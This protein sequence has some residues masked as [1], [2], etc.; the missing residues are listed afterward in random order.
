MEKSDRALV[1]QTP[2]GQNPPNLWAVD[3]LSAAQAGTATTEAEARVRD[4]DLTFS[5]GRAA[6]PSQKDQLRIDFAGYK[7]EVYGIAA[8]TVV[9]AAILALVLAG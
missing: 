2:H 8:I 3:G 6:A 5:P 1:A 9:V 7:I 4:G